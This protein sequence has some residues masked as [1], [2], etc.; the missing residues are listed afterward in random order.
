MRKIY[1]LLTAMMLLIGANNLFAYAETTVAT[2]GDQE[3]DNLPAAMA[4]SSEQY[5]AVL[6]K[7]IT[8]N[9]CPTINGKKRQFIDMNGHNISFNGTNEFDLY[10]QAALTITGTGKITSSSKYGLF[11][12]VGYST[13][14]HSNFFCELTIGEN[15][16]CYNPSYHIVGIFPYSSTGK[17]YGVVVNFNGTAQSPNSYAFSINGT[18]QATTG[19]VPQINIGETA[20]IESGDS[21][22]ALYA[23]G[24]GIWNI[25]GSITGKTGIYVKAGTVNIENAKI[26]AWGDKNEP[27]PHGSG[28]KST[29]DCIIMDSKAGY[30]GN[31]VLSITGEN[32]EL[33]SDNGYAVQEALTDLQETAT[34]GLTIADGTFIGGA[35]AVKYS[36]AFTKA[37]IDGSSSESW[38]LNAITGGEY[39][40]NPLVSAD[41]FVVVDTK[42]GETPFIVQEAT[43]PVPVGGTTYI[44]SK[45][46]FEGDY[47]LDEGRE[48][49]I[50]TG[51]ELDVTGTLTIDDD[52]NNI[53]RVQPN[54]KLVVNNIVSNNV[55]NIIL[56]DAINMN[57]GALIYSGSE[58]TSPKGT[59]QLALSAKKLNDT[60]YKFQHFGIP[61]VGA[62]TLVKSV[63]MAFS[64]WDRTKGWEYVHSDAL[65]APF[66]GRCVTVNTTEAGKVLGFAGGLVTNDDA[67]FTLNR[68][69][70][71][72]LANSYT[73]PMDIQTIHN[74]LDGVNTDKTLWVYIADNEQ[75]KFEQISPDTYYFVGIEKLQPMQGFFLLN[76]G[77]ETSFTVPYQDA[78][79]SDGELKTAT[80]DVIDGGA[81]TI[82]DGTYAADLYLLRSDSYEGISGS[83]QFE[84]SPIKIYVAESGNKWA[85]FKSNTFE[86]QIVEIETTKATNYTLTFSKLMN[87][88]FS[89][90]DLDNPGVEIKVAENGKYEF[91]ATPNTT[92]KRFKLGKGVVEAGG[93]ED[94]T[95][96]MWVNGETLYI[97]NAESDIAVINGAGVTVLNAKA[98]GDAVQAISIADLANG[99][100]L[101]ESGSLKGKFIK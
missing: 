27:E 43:E 34:I 49:V 83:K 75:I 1:F 16:T 100:Y 101:I 23:A 60:D 89:I 91:T 76:E 97:A 98:N 45:T 22:C 40:S 28:A 2:V 42:T 41:E 71:T 39:S 56:E 66:V 94:N 88:G 67:L 37:L 11:Y 8:L 32:T 54:A 53:V 64:N 96:D 35:G 12:M 58:V 26:Y 36:D 52:S 65:N 21:S 6:Q 82:S 18:A 79:W 59:C 30:T 31:M 14:N 99:W 38:T 29:G 74:S 15:V 92:V 80:A 78:V 7:D 4:A 63:Q 90:I 44:T 10:Y 86:G 51:A 17:A 46:T 47:T 9:T 20:K 70:Y 69:G 19:D 48:I 84:G 3:F 85:T 72:A 61:T 87:D 73:A 81:I 62:P 95:L 77:E 33:K 13:S 25:Q 68:S 57:T 55:S 93:V 50:Q 5:P 24:Y